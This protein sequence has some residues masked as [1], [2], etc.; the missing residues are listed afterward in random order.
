MVEEGTIAGSR[1]AIRVDAS[2]TI[3][4]G[5]VMRCLTL[6]R[7]LR[8]RNASVTFV[9]RQHEGNLSEVVEAAGFA[10]CRLPKRDDV[11]STGG[12]EYAEWLGVPQRVDA[13]DTVAALRV[14][15][16]QDWVVVDHYGL[17]ASWEDD[18]R[19]AATHVLA[20]DDI[21]NRTHRCEILF[22]SDHVEFC[23]LFGVVKIIT[24][25]ISFG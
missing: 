9:S 19:G 21:A 25:R 4:S 7:E 17:D 22:E 13:E 3:G 20:I 11:R 10:V 1:V 18:V 12:D 2:V 14:D 24:Q 8:R 15:G 16:T 5:H 23:E 6:A